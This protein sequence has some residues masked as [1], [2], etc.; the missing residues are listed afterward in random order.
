MAHKV[1][2]H[3]P[4]SYEEPKNAMQLYSNLTLL[5]E[6]LKA[7]HMVVSMAYEGRDDYVGSVAYLG[8]KFCDEIER[9]A[10]VLYLFKAKKEG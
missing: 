4:L 2:P 1:C 8:A 5:V 9:R 3:L 10:E 7:M 6:H